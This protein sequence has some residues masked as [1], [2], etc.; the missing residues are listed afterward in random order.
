MRWLIDAPVDVDVHRRVAYRYGLDSLSRVENPIG[1]R[2]LRRIRRWGL[3][4]PDS[5]WIR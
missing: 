3:R 4:R 2:T 1:G 5:R